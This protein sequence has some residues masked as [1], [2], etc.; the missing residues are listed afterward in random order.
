MAFDIN[1][2]KKIQRKILAEF[3]KASPTCHLN[4]SLLGRPGDYGSTPAHPDGISLRLMLP[5][6][7]VE[8]TSSLMKTCS[9]N[10][11]NW[12]CWEGKLM[13]LPT[14]MLNNP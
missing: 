7:M 10:R 13:I 5:D 14:L 11:P 8:S 3:Q 2:K 9:N 12:M 1:A 6:Q 4:R